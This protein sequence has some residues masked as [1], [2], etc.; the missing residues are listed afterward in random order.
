MKSPSLTTQHYFSEL[1][2]CDNGKTIHGERMLPFIT[3]FWWPEN[4]IE[5]L[6]FAWDLFYLALIILF[7]FFYE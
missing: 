4:W 3:I 5:E 6:L 1:L 7:Y 2:H